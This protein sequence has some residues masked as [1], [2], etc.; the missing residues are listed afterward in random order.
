LRDITGR[1][2]EGGP[3]L[4]GMDSFQ[5]RWFAWATEY[6]ETSIYDKEP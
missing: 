1:P 5:V 2:R 6:P 3:R 4:A